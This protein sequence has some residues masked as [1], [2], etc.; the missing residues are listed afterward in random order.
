[1]PYKDKAKRAEAGRRRW[2]KPRAA[3]ASVPVVIPPF[4]SDPAGE[5]ARSSG[6]VLK[7]PAGHPRAGDPMILRDYGVEFIRDALTHRESVL[8]SGE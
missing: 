5:L 6:D 2:A 7:V 3:S 4:A 8:P 1:M